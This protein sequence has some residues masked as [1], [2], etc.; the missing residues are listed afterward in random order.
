MNNKPIVV[1][2]CNPRQVPIK[3][4]K[5]DTIIKDLVR[6]GFGGVGP[7]PTIVYHLCK[8]PESQMTISSVVSDIRTVYLPVT[9]YKDEDTM[10]KNEGNPPE[11][12][13]Q[14]ELAR[15][16]KDLDLSRAQTIAYILPFVYL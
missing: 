15:D 13:K 3:T 2:F 8:S 16:I 4:S 9:Q 5:A 7:T 12:V 14:L 1:D 10:S 11:D 6:R